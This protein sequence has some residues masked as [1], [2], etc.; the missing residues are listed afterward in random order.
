[1]REHQTEVTSYGADPRQPYANLMFRTLYTELEAAWAEEAAH[2]GSP[3]E[4]DVPPEDAPAMDEEQP[5]RVL[6]PDFNTSTSTANPLRAGDRSVPV[7]QSFQ[8]AHNTATLP[9]ASRGVFR[10]RQ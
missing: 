2:E 1:M 9:A 5:G 3:F 6:A 10:A 8:P 7:V 4:D